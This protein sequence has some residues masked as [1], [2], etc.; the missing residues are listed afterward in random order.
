MTS[1]ASRNCRVGLRL[2]LAGAAAV[3]AAGLTVLLLAVGWTGAERS[4]R[5]L[6]ERTVISEA[7]ATAARIASD[8]AAARQ[9]LARLAALPGL[10]DA[11][12]GR[13]VG[14]A[15]PY[16]DLA[17]R[18]VPAGAAIGVSDAL[19]RPVLTRDPTNVP[20]TDGSL[21]PLIRR[22]VEYFGAEQQGGELRLTMLFPLA[23]DAQGRSVGALIVRTDLGDWISAQ[24][25][26]RADRGLASQ[27]QVR[28]AGAA[29]P[30][31][32]GT[33]VPTARIPLEL[34]AAGAAGPPTLEARLPEAALE[35][36]LARTGNQ[37]WMAGVLG[38]LLA[39]LAGLAL[40]HR[41]TS[42]VEQ[43]APPLFGSSTTDPPKRVPPAFGHDEISVLARLIDLRYRRI[44]RQRD[45]LRRKFAAATRDLQRA[46]AV[47]RVG[48]WVFEARA[49]RFSF[50][51]QTA[52]ITGLDAERGI[53]MLALMRRIHRADRS[54]A[55][56]AWRR[57]RRHGH[58]AVQF[59]LPS[60]QGT[61]WISARAETDRD[62]ASDPMRIIGSIQD[63][64]AHKKAKFESTRALAVFRYSAQGIFVTDCDG[65]ILA[66]NPA[67][68]RITGYTAA[69]ACGRT[70]ALLKSGRQDRAFYEEMWRRL[71]TRGRWEGEIWNRRKSG[72]HYPQWL[73]ITH[74]GH[75]AHQPGD[76]V[77]LFSDI[78][79]RKRQEEEAWRRANFDALTGLPGSG[80][81]RDR[82]ADA[83]GATSSADGAAAVLSIHLHGLAKVNALVGH[84]AGDDCTLEAVRRLQ[85]NLRECDVLARRGNNEFLVALR[86]TTERGG[87]D[88][89]AARVIAALGEVRPPGS[90]GH[91]IAPYAGLAV[92]P[93]D[94]RD[95]GALI[96]NAELAM[97][98]ARHAAA[99]LRRYTSELAADEL[100]R[101]RI[102]IDLQEAI[103]LGSFA[104]QYQPVI[105]ARSGRIVSV[106]SLLRWRHDVVGL[107]SPATFVAVAEDC[108]LMPDIAA[109]GLR[110]ALERA[111][112]SQHRR[113]PAI[114]VNVRGLHRDAARL[115]SELRSAL[116]PPRSNVPRLTLEFP[117]AALLDPIGTTSACLDIGRRHGA[118]LA[119]DDF[120]QQL[121]SL[122]HLQRYAI[123]EIKI[124]PELVRNCVRSESV[125]RAIE[126]MVAVA[127]KLGIAVTAKGVE[128]PAQAACVRQAGCD[129][130]QGHLI[131]PPMDRDELEARLD[132]PML[133]PW[134]DVDFSV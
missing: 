42:R 37:L 29:D 41:L 97:L 1:G 33:A 86:R 17:A 88:A 122:T 31:P 45:R 2:R 120:G 102:Q 12:V 79:A 84:D 74:V 71:K 116:I 73:T 99:P 103:A 92:A 105:D 107:V 43:L 108:G 115:E 124:D 80:L 51:P 38:V 26:T 93:S 132:Q 32:G 123:D 95:A 46:Q 119:I 34:G 13:G 6:A 63:I 25:V 82:L 91:V 77:A 111:T 53:S 133:P 48:S 112:T 70:P 109:W 75:D 35:A 9:R 52:A 127:H 49:H 28:L 64:T 4:L 94:G 24:R 44:A 36:A 131:A 30:A 57:C 59:R 56:G 8:L 5:Q 76:F 27:I 23:G 54:A 96:H 128:D 61:L 55:I 69:E 72:E 125:A 126:A 62:D 101:R 104:L 47:A 68:T 14:S 89:L 3:L 78:T 20:A 22:G 118:R 83:L 65:R 90:P 15:V 66:V 58:C 117:E 67:F 113:W 40:A 114:S 7:G 81:F 11:V 18:E 134:D 16:L 85:A 129:R 21:E 50:S 19:G 60:P 10:A 39:V 98:G 87:A 106:E 121:A 110:E 100:E 130:L